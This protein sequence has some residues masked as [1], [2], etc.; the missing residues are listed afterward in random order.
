VYLT[1]KRD[2]ETA[3]IEEV[4]DTPVITVVDPAVPPSRR[5]KPR[6]GLIISL[7]LVLGAVIGVFGAFGLEYI[8]YARQEDDDKYQNFREVLKRARQ[9]LSRLVPMGKSRRCGG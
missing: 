1:L 5:S 9:D 4:N 8:D 2:Y 6:R 7:G 3:R